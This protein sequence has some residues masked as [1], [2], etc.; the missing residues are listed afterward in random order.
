MKCLSLPPIDNG[1]YLLD[2]VQ[3]TCTINVSINSHTVSVDAI[4]TRRKNE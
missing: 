1:S 2:G 3:T 4:V